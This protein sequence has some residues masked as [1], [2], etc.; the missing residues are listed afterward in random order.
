MGKLNKKCGY[1]GLLF[2]PLFIALFASSSVSA[3]SP[4]D[5]ISQVTDELRVTH[6]TGSP[7]ADI[8]ANWTDYIN[9]ENQVSGSPTDCDTTHDA[10]IEAMDT[11]QY[12]VVQ[13]QSY[14]SQQ[15]VWIAFNNDT[16]GSITFENPGTGAYDVQANDTRAFVQLYYIGS[17]LKADCFMSPDPIIMPIF[18]NGVTYPSPVNNALFEN[19]YPFEYPP[20]Y[21]GPDLPSG[22]PVVEPEILDPQYSWSLYKDE[23]DNGILNVKYLDNLPHFLTGISYL[24]VERMTEDW[25]SLDE[26][27]ASLGANPAGWANWNVNIGPGQGWYMIRLDH[28]QQLDE[29]PWPEGNN[30]A[31]GQLYYQFFWDGE[32]ALQGSIVNC[33]GIVCNDFKTE[34]KPQNSWLKSMTVDTF[35]LASII[36]A[37]LEFFQDLPDAVENCTP[38]AFPFPM[39]NITIPCMTPWYSDNL[40]SFFTIYQTV[41]LGVFSYFMGLNLFHRIKHISNPKNDQ[42]E[43]VHL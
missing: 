18:T 32:T 5:S 9:T 33:S 40:G 28:N 27:V 20:D 6:Y 3:V 4:W 24:V 39:G 15:V 8:T 30:Y 10:L 23:N 22:G 26:T 16:D 38:L 11:G 43:V 25:E 29:P 19:T 41:V 21:E 17:D 37:P 13:N 1:L 42:I 34:E 12:A 2:A 14:M 7:S 35:G 31:I 36:T